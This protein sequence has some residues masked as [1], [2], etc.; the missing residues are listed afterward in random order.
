[1]PKLE[2]FTNRVEIDGYSFIKNELRPIDV[3]G[4]DKVSGSGRI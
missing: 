4:T 1:M 3:S 2:N